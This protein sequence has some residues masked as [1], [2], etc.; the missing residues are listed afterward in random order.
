MSVRDK[1]KQLIVEHLGV[2]ESAVE[3]NATITE[4]LGA[5]S[6]DT[7]EL[8][9]VLEEAFDIDIPDSDAEKIKTVKDV[10]DYIEARK[11]E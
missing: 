1:V 10:I 8:I 2:E 4:D 9:M 11:G 5:D 7:V 6:L 3:D